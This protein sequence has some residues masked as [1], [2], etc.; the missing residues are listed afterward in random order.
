MCV[1]ERERERE[2]E[3]EKERERED[4]SGRLMT[5]MSFSP[6]NSAILSVPGVSLFRGG[7]VFKAHRLVYRSTLGWRVIKKKKKSSVARLS[8]AEE[9]RKSCGE[10][11]KLAEHHLNPG[12]HIFLGFFGN[13]F[14]YSNASIL[15]VR[16]FC[17]VKFAAS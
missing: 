2:R 11:A 8:G 6:S 17:V 12:K 7:L 10:E 14:H 16:G 3:R 1:C 13:V 4:Q 5:M 9:G 15:L